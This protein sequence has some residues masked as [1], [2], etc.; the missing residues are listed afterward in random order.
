MVA[1]RR[2]LDEWRAIEIASN[3]AKPAT[4]TR[5]V[6]LG[7]MKVV[8]Y[9]GGRN[10]NKEIHGGISVIGADLPLPDGWNQYGFARPS[11]TDTRVNT[12]REHN[13]MS[14]D[15]PGSPQNP[16]VETAQATQSAVEEVQAV[17]AAVA[18]IVP[19]PTVPA[20]VQTSTPSPQAVP[21]PQ[22]DEG[23]ST[24]T[25]P[26]VSVEH[27]KLPELA[28]P[29]SLPPVASPHVET[30]NADTESQVHANVSAL[31]ADTDDT[32]EAADT[33]NDTKENA[34]PVWTGN[35][36]VALLFSGGI[37]ST[38]MFLYLLAKGYRVAP[39]YV[40]D[41][42]AEKT[43]TREANIC[44]KIVRIA[45]ANIPPDKD[46]GSL[47]EPLEY[48]DVRI[49]KAQLQRKRR[50]YVEL[51]TRELIGHGF[52]AIAYGKQGL[53]PDPS[54]P[55]GEDEEAADTDIMFLQELTPLQVI[56]PETFDLPKLESV[57]VAALEA[58]D[59]S[60]V[61]SMLFASTSCEQ[62]TTLECGNCRSC[63]QRLQLF[64]RLF[65][66]DGTKYV[67]GSRA[68]IRRKKVRKLVE[69]QDPADLHKIKSILSPQKKAK[70]VNKT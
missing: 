54:L 41:A 69:S 50:R 34:N 64:W 48:I 45:M 61:K 49:M 2:R 21:T 67:K 38:A 40:R 25:L 26:T 7:K 44:G 14:T 22:V 55:E 70:P 16:S 51:L 20:P 30:V 59:E 37:N 52:N 13:Q 42:A 12:D 35:P 10:Q 32:V 43:S 29:S 18:Q 47:I 23:K 4:P 11:S 31:L 56:S 62:R 1:E 66:E 39:Y 3:L 15:N 24:V 33:G 58:L 63:L 17:Q 8:C 60:F 5:V 57:I 27:F 9:C 28:K 6:D 65:I 53:A 36:K 68:R 46:G 19:P